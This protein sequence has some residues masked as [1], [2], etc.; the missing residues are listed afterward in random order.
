MSKITRVLQK[1]FAGSATD[2]G[3]FGSGATGD[4]TLSTDV[5]TLQGLGAWLTGWATATI[6]AKKFPP[7][8][9]M[10]ALHYV[11]TTQLAYLFQ[12]GVPEYNSS[13]TYYIGSVV[14]K[15]GTFEL[16]VPSG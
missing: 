14:K 1:V 3:V 4:K 13:T 2:I 15:T 7:L 6:G 16:Y 9:E 12:E 10:N 11:E 8:E 5:S